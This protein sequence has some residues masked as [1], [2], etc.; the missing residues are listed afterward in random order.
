MT[1]I[2]NETPELLT[3]RVY[4]Y[5]QNCAL[6]GKV[7][8]EEFDPESADYDSMVVSTAR[9][10]VDTDCH[11]NI[12]DSNQLFRLRAAKNVLEFAGY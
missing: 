5:S 8:L 1:D 7:I 11:G 6:A 4:F 2:Y 10:I 12:M 3:D 9:H